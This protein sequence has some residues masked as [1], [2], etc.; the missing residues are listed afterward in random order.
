M[1]DP[2]FDEASSA[3]VRVLVDALS[4]RAGGGAT[5]VTSLIP[6]LKKRHPALTL[7][8]LLSSEYQCDLVN[9]LTPH[10][11]ILDSRLHPTPLARRMLYL[12]VTVPRLVVKHKIDLLFSVA[13]I[14]SPRPGCPT[15]HV[16][17]NA[18]HFALSDRPASLSERATRQLRRLTL[19]PFVRHSIRS[20]DTLVF[21]SQSLRSLVLSRMDVASPMSVI[22]HGVHESFSG[23][24]IGES[25]YPELADRKFILSVSTIMPYKN[26]DTL[27]HAFGE[28]TARELPSDIDLVIAGD[29]GSKQTF[30]RLSEIV[31]RR[32]LK[33]RVHFLGRASRVELLFLYSRALFSVF[34]S[35]AESFGHPLVESMAAGCPVVASS[36]PV[37]Y[38]LCGEAA[39]YFDPDDVKRLAEILAELSGGES[40]RDEMA[41]LGRRRATAF[42]WAIAADRYASIFREVGGRG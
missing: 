31:S 13:E 16:F 6:E 12:L 25:P 21:V 23:R 28:A 42:S 2:P 26:M 34:P 4:A 14:S 39:M 18:N 27:V 37:A 1:T 30:S 7:Y 22:Y 10:A 38:E 29:I 17:R 35:R 11:H 33:D 9:S 24:F 8:V 19:K 41:R 3:R 15:V 36:L 20:S 40:K 32:S 5:F